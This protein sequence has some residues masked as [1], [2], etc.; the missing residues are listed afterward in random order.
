MVLVAKS[1][2]LVYIFEYTDASHDINK[3][4]CNL[5]YMFNKLC[6]RTHLYI[7]FFIYI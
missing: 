2:K 5:M 3:Y 6:A 7:H 1:L 4:L